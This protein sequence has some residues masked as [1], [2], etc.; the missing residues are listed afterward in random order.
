LIFGNFEFR[1]E[2][3]GRRGREKAKKKKYEPRV[4]TRWCLRTGWPTAAGTPP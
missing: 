4:P 2:Q 3:R 1:N